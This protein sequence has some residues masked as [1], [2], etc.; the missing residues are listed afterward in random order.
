MSS[1][2]SLVKGLRNAGKQGTETD[3]VNRRREQKK[4]AQAQRK[5]ATPTVSKRKK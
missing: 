4:R 2:D 1:Y 3:F 5:R